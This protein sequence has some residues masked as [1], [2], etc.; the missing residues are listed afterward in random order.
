[1]AIFGQIRFTFPNLSEILHLLLQE[2]GPL[3]VGVILCTLSRKNEKKEKTEPDDNF[4]LP[5]K[6]HKLEKF[7]DDLKTDYGRRCIFE[8]LAIET[9][10]DIFIIATRWVFFGRMIQIDMIDQGG[11]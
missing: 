3:V 1:M 4:A 10:M 2:K 5:E 11:Q 8:E 9:M 6:F 7:F